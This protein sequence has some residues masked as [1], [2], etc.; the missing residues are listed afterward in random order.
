MPS[1]TVEM[2]NDLINM[3]EDARNFYANASYQTTSQRWREVFRKIAST[4]ESIIIN[5]KSHL[6]SMVGEVAEDGSPA[7]PSSNI[8]KLL[9]TD[10]INGDLALVEKLE[11]AENETLRKFRQAIENEPPDATVNLIERQMQILNETHSHMKFLRQSLGKA[12]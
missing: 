12:A 10:I 5:L 1:T 11:K 6:N 4:R 8:F 2:L 7:D 9:N 3:C